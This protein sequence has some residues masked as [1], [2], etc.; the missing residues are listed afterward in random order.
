MNRFASKVLYCGIFLA[1]PTANWIL[2]SI[3]L[4]TGIAKST[5]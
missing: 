1:P 3:K 4:L 2:H 5:T